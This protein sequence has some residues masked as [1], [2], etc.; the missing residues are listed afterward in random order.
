MLR[1]LC[2]FGRREVGRF[3]KL[4][5]Y[6]NLIDNIR[7]VSVQQQQLRIWA[8]EVNQISERAIAWNTVENS[9]RSEPV[10][11]IIYPERLLGSVEL[12]DRYIEG[13]SCA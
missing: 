6:D 3:G 4:L 2:G 7:E 13:G 8:F 1:K 12:E 9:A 11:D 10:N 5:E